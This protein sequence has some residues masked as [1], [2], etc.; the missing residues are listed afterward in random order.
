M[1]GP[2]EG[3]LKYTDGKIYLCTTSERNCSNKNDI[4]YSQKK[5]IDIA[6][7]AALHYM[8]AKHESINLRF[9]LIDDIF[10][11]IDDAELSCKT[12]LINFLRTV[13]EKLQIVVF[14][15]DEELNQ[16]LLLEEVHKLELSHH[17]QSQQIELS[18]NGQKI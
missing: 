16:R 11:N 13:A 15:I 2:T 9:G 18:F 17:T 8:N 12:N 10:M 14:S 5:L 6:L 7:W 4:S 1:V 3:T